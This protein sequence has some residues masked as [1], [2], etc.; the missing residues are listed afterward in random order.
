[1]CIERRLKK[2][3]KLFSVIFYSKMELTLNVYLV[4]LAK[5]I[6]NAI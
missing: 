6:C 2:I 4:Y 5:S 3:H 1:M